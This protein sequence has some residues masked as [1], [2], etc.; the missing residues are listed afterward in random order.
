MGRGLKMPETAAI[1]QAYWPEWQV[2]KRTKDLLQGT[3]P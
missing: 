3:M 2:R 1:L